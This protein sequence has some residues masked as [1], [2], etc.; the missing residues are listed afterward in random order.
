MKIQSKVEHNISFFAPNGVAGLP[1]YLTIIAGATH[2]F[3]DNIWIKG[4]A[5]AAADAI[6]AGQLVILE[7][8]VT[9]LTVKQITAAIKD[10]VGVTIDAKKTKSELQ[11]IA[12]KLGVDLSQPV[13]ED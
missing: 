7:E 8:P 5:S 3:D 13:S 2:E 1:G 9:Q 12:G 6:H 4:F 10:Q 11:A